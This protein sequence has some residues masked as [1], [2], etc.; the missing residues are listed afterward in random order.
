[1]GMADRGDEAV[2]GNESASVVW[3]FWP[4][5]NLVVRG[6]GVVHLGLTAE[7]MPGMV[8]V[9]RVVGGSKFGWLVSC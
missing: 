5:T 9:V 8:R 3:K 1:M 7:R 2:K 6:D 4:V